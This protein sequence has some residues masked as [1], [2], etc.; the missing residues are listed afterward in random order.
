MTTIQKQRLAS[1]L[2]GFGALLLILVIYRGLAMGPVNENRVTILGFNSISGEVVFVDNEQKQS[3]FLQPNQ[4]ALWQELMADEPDAVDLTWQRGLR[5]KQILGFAEGDQV[6]WPKARGLAEMQKN[7][8]KTGVIGAGFI[9]FSFFLY[10]WRGKAD[11]KSGGSS[12][13]NEFRARAT[14]SSDGEVDLGRWLGGLL[15]ALLLVVL[16]TGV[17]SYL[18]TRGFYFILVMPI[19]AAWVYSRYFDFWQNRAFCRKSSLLNLGRILLISSHILGLLFWL[20]VW[21][22]QA[23]NLSTFLRGDVYLFDPQQAWSIPHLLSWFPIA[24]ELSSF[25][26]Y[27]FV[28]FI[29][30]FFLLS[31]NRRWVVFLKS[32]QKWAKP[33]II[34][35]TYWSHEQVLAAFKAQDA[36]E[37]T[38]LQ[39][40]QPSQRQPL[41]VGLVYGEAGDEAFLTLKNCQGLARLSAQT[42]YSAQGP[43]IVEQMKLTVDEWALIEQV[44]KALYL[45]ELEEENP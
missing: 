32:R 23:L 41:L 19:L 3:A 36:R 30:F 8:V 17:F 24:R 27:D 42:V 29:G 28:L 18:A 44:R 15:P 35:F 33:E 20:F 7:Q 13:L 37:L 25:Y 14:Y 26:L 40:N 34:Y 39:V 43:L 6:Y 22:D 2:A 11:G 16:V 5:Q 10:R 12:L 38:N 1:I 4:V 9:L 21:C 31:G 45:S